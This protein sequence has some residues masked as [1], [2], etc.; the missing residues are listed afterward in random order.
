VGSERELLQPLLHD[1]TFAW[2]AA[3]LI[4]EIE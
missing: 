2:L 3:G 1:E 4:G